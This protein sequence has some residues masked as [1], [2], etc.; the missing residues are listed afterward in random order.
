M[1]TKFGLAL[2]AGLA[3][4]VFV[5]QGCAHH[6]G[7]TNVRMTTSILSTDEKRQPEPRRTIL[8]LNHPTPESP[9]LRVA[10][11]EELIMERPAR[12]EFSGTEM[13]VP[14]QWTPRMLEKIPPVSLFFAVYKPF[15]DL[16]THDAG[17]WGMGDYLRDFLAWLNPFEAMPDGTQERGDERVIF[18]SEN[19]WAP[20]QRQLLPVLR[21]G[22]DVRIGGRLVGSLTTDAD[23][24]A[25]LDLRRLARE[26]PGSDAVVLTFKSQDAVRRIVLDRA[27]I[28]SLYTVTR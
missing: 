18:R 15:A 10:L 6:V 9:T 11:M 8:E 19:A 13:R 12:I 14:F 4:A 5:A 26:L 27:L 24:M 17:V 3:A 21:N 23:G 16:H 28:A 1:F 22:I 2:L 25:S 7:Y 20:V